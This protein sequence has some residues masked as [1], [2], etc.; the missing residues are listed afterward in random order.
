MDG[1]GI[2]SW[3]QE[4][5]AAFLADVVVEYFLCTAAENYNVFAGLRMPMDWDDRSGLDGVQH[6]L[7]LVLR[8]VPKI[9]IHSQP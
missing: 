5:T 7:A 6:P 4:V 3:D 9:H 1:R 8:S 2:T